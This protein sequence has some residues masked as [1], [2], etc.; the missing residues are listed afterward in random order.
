MLSRIYLA[1]KGKI[2]RMDPVKSKSTRQGGGGLRVSDFGSQGSGAPAP[3][4]RPLTL[5]SLNFTLPSL[6]SA[7]VLQVLNRPL[8]DAGAESLW[9]RN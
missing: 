6:P 5:P 8:F 9:I 3:T 4:A 1:G 2:R 7:S